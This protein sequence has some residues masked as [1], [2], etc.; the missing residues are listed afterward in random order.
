MEAPPH[1][2][3]RVLQ[4]GTLQRKNTGQSTEVKNITSKKKSTHQL[5]HGP[6]EVIPLLDHGME[7]ALEGGDPTLRVELQTQVKLAK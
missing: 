6:P 3:L 5:G 1:H 7:D 2:L 4:L